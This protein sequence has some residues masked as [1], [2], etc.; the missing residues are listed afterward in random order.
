MLPLIR[1]LLP[2]PVKNALKAFGRAA[3]PVKH[4]SRF[5]NFYHCS[6]IR[7]G[8]LWMRGILCDLR[9]HRWSGLK[10]C[11]FDRLMSSLARGGDISRYPPTLEFGAPC[12]PRTI[13]TPSHL[14]AASYRTIP[15]PE[16]HR[17]I[18]VV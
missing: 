3:L 12:P 13:L 7:S 8:T 5:T 14:D 11:N 18:V 4:R 1:R 9:L 2:A 17:A 16:S 6:L 15:K 10:P